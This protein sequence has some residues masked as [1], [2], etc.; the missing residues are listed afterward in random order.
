MPSREGNALPPPPP[1]SLVSL[2]RL[3]LRVV[4]TSAALLGVLFLPYI[5]FPVI[6]FPADFHESYSIVFGHPFALAVLPQWM[7]VCDCSTRDRRLTFFDTL[8][9]IVET[10]WCMLRPAIAGI[11]LLL[12][13]TVAWADTLL[14]M[15][16]D[17][18]HGHL[19]KLSWDV[20]ASLFAITSNYTL[21]AS[22]LTEE[23]RAT[24]CALTLSH[25]YYACVRGERSA[26]VAYVY[27]KKELSKHP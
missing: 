7:T 22:M 11:C 26:C 4:A 16:V 23:Q 15:R 19:R 10:L 21:P 25:P 14:F 2:I 1:A 6:E 3:F 12:R 24:T 5:I 27:E 9:A 8:S 20:F 17:Y 13:F 18:D